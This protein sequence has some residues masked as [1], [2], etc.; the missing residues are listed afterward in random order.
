MLE[1]VDPNRPRG[2]GGPG[3]VAAGVGR[4]GDTYG[5]ASDTRAGADREA[6]AEREER[7]LEP[8]HVLAVLPDVLHRAREVER[9]PALRGH[10]PGQGVEQG[11]VAR[12]VAADHRRRER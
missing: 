9:E 10:G 5:G 2:S 4:V 12:A 1:W 3:G 7:V 6:V 8:G 11:G